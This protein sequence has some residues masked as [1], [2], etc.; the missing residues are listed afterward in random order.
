MAEDPFPESDIQLVGQEVP[1]LLWNL[2][3]LC[4]VHKSTQLD[5]VLSH[6]NSI[7]KSISC[8]SRFNVIVVLSVPLQVSEVIFSLQVFEII[9]V[10]FPANLIPHDFIT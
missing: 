7:Y 10:T 6:M 3:I 9:L 2:K 5:L 1:R 4:V 8:F